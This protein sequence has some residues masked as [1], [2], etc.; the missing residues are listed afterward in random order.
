MQ[1]TA[2]PTNIIIIIHHLIFALWTDK[3]D[4]VWH[5]NLGRHMNFEEDCFHVVLFPMFV[6]FKFM[7]FIPPYKNTKRTSFVY[8]SLTCFVA[9][10]CSH[11]YR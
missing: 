8:V 5:T 6:D 7:D 9:G 10:K 3:K 1:D 2:C 4:A 11:I